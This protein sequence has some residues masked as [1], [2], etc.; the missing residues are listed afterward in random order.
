MRLKDCGETSALFCGCR[1]DDLV[2]DDDVEAGLIGELLTSRFRSRTREP[3]LLPPSAVMCSRVPERKTRHIDSKEVPDT[4][5][6]F[7][8]C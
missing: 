5:R 1:G 8:E 6:Q 2:A 4:P 3:L 7:G